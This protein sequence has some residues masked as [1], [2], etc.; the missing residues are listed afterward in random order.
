MGNHEML[1]QIERLNSIVTNIVGIL[2]FSQKYEAV[3]SKGLS[4]IKIADSVKKACSISAGLKIPVT[5][6]NLG[7]EVLADS[8]L[9]EIFNNLLDNSLKYGGSKLSKVEISTRLTETGDLQIIFID[10]GE[11]IDPDIKPKLFNKGVGK[12]TGLGLYLIQRICDVYGWSIS[13]Q[14]KQGHGVRFVIV[15]PALN[16]KALKS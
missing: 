3:G 7:F 15:V 11:G 13:E 8:A 5:T 1:T 12:G 16:V 4:W 10:N 2:D 9:T 6:K 14:G